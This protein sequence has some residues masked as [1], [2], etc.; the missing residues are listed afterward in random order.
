MLASASSKLND[1]SN[2]DFRVG[3]EAG[4][5]DE[6]DCF[7]VEGYTGIPL[8]FLC[9]YVFRRARCYFDRT[10]GVLRHQGTSSTA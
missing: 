3:D 6:S 5:D 8:G 1:N 4:D 10:C 2:G 9:M 7:G